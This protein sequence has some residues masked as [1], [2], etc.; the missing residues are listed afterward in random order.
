MNNNNLFWVS[1]F[2]RMGLAFTFIYAGISAFLSPDNWIGFL[3]LW[4]EVF[5]SLNV[6]LYI[7]NVFVIFLG[8]WLLTNKKTYYSGIVS[9]SFF[10]MLL[11]FNISSMDLIFRDVGLLFSAL[12]LIFLN[13]KESSFINPK[14]LVPR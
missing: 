4:L 12:A 8:V 3:P 7:H 11:V 10:L 9:A 2:L 13:K 5:L 1:L 6:F 14:N